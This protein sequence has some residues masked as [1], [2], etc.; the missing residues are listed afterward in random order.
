[1]RPGTGV[2]DAGYIF[3]SSIPRDLTPRSPAETAQRRRKAGGVFDSPTHTA[4]HSDIR[5]GAWLPWRGR[6]SS[7]ISLCVANERFLRRALPDEFA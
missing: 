4:L 6:P 2:V 1:V 3:F 7:L 5:G